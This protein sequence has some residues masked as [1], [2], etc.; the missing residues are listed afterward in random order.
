MMK[1]EAFAP[2]LIAMLTFCM[3]C[4][5]SA[6]STDTEPP[7]FQTLQKQ[8]GQDGFDP[9][10]I[11]AIY[12]STRVTFDTKTV[13]L[14][15]VHREATL[16]YDQFISK[17][18]I[19]KAKGYMKKFKTELDEAHRTYG[20]DPEVIT[21]ILLVETRLGAGTG[22]SSVIST[23][24]TMAALQDPTVR[25]AF[26]KAVSQTVD[27]TREEFETWSDRKST[28][29]Y[30]ELK[31][32]LEY[33]GREQLEPTDI[34]GSYAGAMGISQFMPSNVLAYAKDGNGDGKI[35]LFDHGDAIASVA[36]YLKRHGWKP[37]HDHEKARKVVWA[38]NRSSYYVDIIFKISDRLKG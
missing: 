17:R 31:A 37:G 32:F 7:I 26:W 28:W 10:R 1:K 20:V 2:A 3:V 29:A 27:V 24:S 15:L 5:V 14:F 21:A 36:N 34:R 16:N 8:L 30:R 38:Y 18:S 12:T 9:K 25:D 35:D 23:L 11:D 6:Q 22:K 13:S 19:H 4:S 33:T